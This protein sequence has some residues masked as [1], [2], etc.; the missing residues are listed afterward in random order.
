M[1]FK[2]DDAANAA[3]VTEEHKK[4]VLQQVMSPSSLEDK[5]SYAVSKHPPNVTPLKGQSDWA[6]WKMIM[7]NNL[8]LGN[9]LYPF[10]ELGEKLHPVAI[11]IVL[12]KIVQEETT[13][14]LRETHR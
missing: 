7:R 1:E 14:P 5:H 13:E 10:I 4:L 2:A 11:N 3:V 8:S 12:A 9:L 6:D